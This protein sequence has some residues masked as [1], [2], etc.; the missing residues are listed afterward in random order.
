VQVTGLAT[1]ASRVAAAIAARRPAAALDPGASASTV[2][3]AAHGPSKDAASARL[4]RIGGLARF[5]S[6]GGNHC[7][8]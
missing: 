8:G 2:R 7:R 3:K 1:P 6:G 5:R 4:Q